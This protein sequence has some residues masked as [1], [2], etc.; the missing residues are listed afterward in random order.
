MLKSVTPKEFWEIFNKKLSRKR[1]DLGTQFLSAYRE[2]TT[3]T[4]DVLKLLSDIG[5]ENGYVDSKSCAKEYMLIDM[6]YFDFNAY[7]DWDF[8]VAI[9]HEND[10]TKW[11]EEFIKLIHVNC[12]LKVIIT[13]GQESETKGFILTEKA[14]EIYNKRVYKNPHDNW[15]FIFGP[16]KKELKNGKW[17]KAY[18]LEMVDAKIEKFIEI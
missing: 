14:K 8:D 4:N 7:C 16:T 12:G 2:D 15:L 11:L 3:W 9:E 1:E 6:G 17:F 13:Y 18:T 5:S 10:G